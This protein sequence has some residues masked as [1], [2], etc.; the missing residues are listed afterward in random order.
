MEFKNITLSTKDYIARVTINRPDVRNALNT[1]TFSEL[2]EA[3]HTIG[4]D[5]SVGVAVVT[6]AGD[7]AFAAGADIRSAKE[8]A[9]TNPIDGLRLC[10]EFARMGHEMRTCGKPIIGRV[11]GEVIGGG[12]E[13]MLFCDLII[14]A[15][16]TKLTGG[17][18]FIGA[19]P[20]GATQLTPMIMG[21]KRARWF[22]LTDE[23][24]DAQTALEWGLINKVVPFECLDEEVDKLS[25]TLLHKFPWALRF[26]KT[27]LNFWADLSSTVLHQG[28]DFWG[29]HVGTIP[30]MMEGISSFLEKREARWMEMRAKAAAGKPAE[31]HWGAPVKECSK[32]GAVNLPEEFKFCGTCGEMLSAGQ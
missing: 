15:D 1:E 24:I 4:Y 3:F 23:K 29:M 13:L 10:G 11:F 12:V 14:A 17:E 25:Q 7:K 22:L 30:E 9:C 2:A 18:A 6:G 31:Y 27:Q 21:D 32:C 5:P 28:R 26:T 19:V 16:N 20:I 8:G